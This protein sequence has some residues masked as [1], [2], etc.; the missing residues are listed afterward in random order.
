MRKPTHKLVLRAETIQT[1][2]SPRILSP[3]SLAQALG[4]DAAVSEAGIA[5]AD[6]QTYAECL[7]QR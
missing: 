6:K 2:L 3:Q 7:A 4:G 1:L 5:L